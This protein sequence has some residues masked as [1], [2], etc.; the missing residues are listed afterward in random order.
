MAVLKLISLGVLA[1]FSYDFIVF[2]HCSHSKRL[3]KLFED[4]ESVYSFLALPDALH[5]FLFGSLAQIDPVDLLFLLGTQAA[6]N[7]SLHILGKQAEYILIDDPNLHRS[8][9]GD[10]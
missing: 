10:D 7:F 9:V 3:L 1:I 4:I 6:N 2:L 8:R 5:L